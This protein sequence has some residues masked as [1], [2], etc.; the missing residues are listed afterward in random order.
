MRGTL[1]KSRHGESDTFYG[2]TRARILVYVPPSLI[3][4]VHVFRVPENCSLIFIGLFVIF[5]VPSLGESLGEY[6][7]NIY[8]IQ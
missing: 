8:S 2:G 5:V 4:K 6:T 7:S 3:S 1:C